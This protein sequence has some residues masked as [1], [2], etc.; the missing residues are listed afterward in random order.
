M[1]RKGRILKRVPSGPRR[2]Y[3]KYPLLTG[4]Q[5]LNSKMFIGGLNWETTDRMYTRYAD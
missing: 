3:E 4:D 2:F 1:Q 5:P